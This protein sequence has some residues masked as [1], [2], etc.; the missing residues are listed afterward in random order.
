MASSC[1]T[2]RS[3]IDSPPECFVRDH[4]GEGGTV[5][6][7]TS[8]RK[9]DLVEGRT[10]NSQREAHA[11]INGKAKGS[12]QELTV[13][14]RAPATPG[15]IAILGRALGQA[16]YRR[17]LGACKSKK[18]ALCK[19]FARI[20]K[21][22]RT[23]KFRAAEKARARFGTARKRNR[24]R[25]PE[26]IYLPEFGPINKP[27]KD[28]SDLIEVLKDASSSRN[29]TGT[30]PGT[31]ESS[32]TRDA[33][34]E[35]PLPSM[36]CIKRE[37]SFGACRAVYQSHR[38]VIKFFFG[39][40]SPRAIALQ[41]EADYYNTCLLPVQGT[42]VPYMYGLYRGK[43]CDERK[44]PVSCL[45]L[46]DCGDV[47]T[48]P[49]RELPMEPEERENHEN[50]L[51]AASALR[52]FAERNVV[53]KN[54]SYRFIDFVDVNDEHKCHWKGQ[55][56]EGMPAPGMR[57]LGCSFILG[58]GEVMSLWK[59][60]LKHSSSYLL[61]VSL[62]EGYVRV[63]NRLMRV[64]NFPSQEDVDF[65]CNNASS[66][67]SP[68]KAETLHNWLKEYKNVKGR[69]PLEEYATTRPDLAW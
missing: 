14:L 42:I 25:T 57:K 67:L 24:A 13:R 51:R 22:S 52:D 60:R 61:T 30:G 11:N 54:G 1:S 59:W 45:I 16:L 12:E 44:L 63:I 19:K 40:E 4:D 62:A 58:A 48:Q 55:L 35:L 34:I 56:C 39:R 69:V 8:G 31:Q 36:Q 46:E 10:Q 50:A 21:S 32:S 7:T 37:I 26:G 3:R 2:V 20:E 47:L 29:S 66:Q 23:K 49:F 28:F 43:T 6:T 5:A 38:L 65:L 64:E 9:D 53:Q 15:I 27:Q 68:M 41:R 33:P 17:W 18:F